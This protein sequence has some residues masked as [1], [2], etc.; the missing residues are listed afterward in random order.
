MT[1]PSDEESAPRETPATHTGALTPAET[2]LEQAP[3]N[4]N[5]NSD[6]HEDAQQENNNTNSD[7]SNDDDDITVILLDPDEHNHHSNVISLDWINQQGPEME[8]RRR[9]VLLRELQ[10]VQRASFMH[11]ALLCLIPSALLLV[12]VLALLSDSEECTSDVTHCELEP[13]TFVNAFTTR[14]ICDP[15]PVLRTWEEEGEV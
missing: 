8:A 6:Q 13:R 12:V 14:C 4:N 2:G 5:N 9:N 3:N 10:R 7:S 15:I 11:F 1:L